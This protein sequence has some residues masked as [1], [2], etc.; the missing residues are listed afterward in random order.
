MRQFNYRARNQQGEEVKGVIETTNEK[1]AAKILRDRNY[2][3]VSLKEKKGFTLF[4]NIN[5]LNKVTSKDVTVFT[6]QLGVMIR[7]GLT[8]TDALNILKR[9]AKPQLSAVLE[10]VTEEIEAGSSF[11]EALKN[12]QDIFSKTYL[13][14][15]RSGEKSGKLDE[16]LIRLADNLEKKEEFK[17]KVKGALIYPSI[18]II[19]MIAV[20]FIMMVFVV[21]KLTSMY[22]DFGVSLPLPTRI[23]IGLSTFMSKFWY[24]FILMVG[25]LIFFFNRWKKTEEGRAFIDKWLLEIPIIGNVIKKSIL[26][27]LSQTMSMLV[28]A[29]VPII[30]VLEIVAETSNN[31]LFEKSIKEVAERLEKGVPL[32]STFSSYLI[33][34][35]LFVQMV[36]VG[37]ET[38]KLG[39]VLEKVS[40][41]FE[42]ETETAVKGLTS[43][44]EPLMMVV[45]GIGVGFLVIS[46]ITPIYQLTSSF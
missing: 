22:E 37:E 19:G 40:Y 46:I 35:P 7:T 39:E 16:V 14:L 21:P 31:Y 4:G 32:A 11:H 34:P 30:D 13:A 36:S 44:M 5:F 42:M 28:E 15:V 18:V 27:Q 20:A 41:H 29:G 23:L 12:H 3:V 9:D 17:G 24:L 25:G 43:A 8:L 38:G 10:K 45:L 33:Y 6:R 2:I 1:H 26:T